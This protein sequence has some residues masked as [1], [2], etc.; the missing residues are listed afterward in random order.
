MKILIADDSLH[1]RI[2][3][4]KKL[5]EIKEIEEIHEADNYVNTIDQLEKEEPDFLI[6]DIRLPDESGIH[7]LDYLQDQEKKPVVMVASDYALENNRSQAMEK[8]ADFVFDKAKDKDK[9]IKTI[10]E[11]QKTSG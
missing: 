7:V 5:S 6:L 3:M 11:Y 10:K 8:G 4:K 9:I 2:I 1:F